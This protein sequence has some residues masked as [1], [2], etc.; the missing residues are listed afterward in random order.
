M[1]LFNF[2]ICVYF[3][4]SVWSFDENGALE[5]LTLCDAQYVI[6]VVVMFFL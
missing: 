6:L 4:F 1:V 5:L 2:I 3:G